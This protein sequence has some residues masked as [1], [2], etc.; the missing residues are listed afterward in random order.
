M[1]AGGRIKMSGSGVWTQNSTFQKQLFGIFESGQAPGGTNGIT[2]NTGLYTLRFDSA[3]LD[4][5][6]SGDDYTVMVTADYGGDDPTAS[7]RTVNVMVQTDSSFQVVWERADT[8]D[9]ENY[10]DD[11]HINFRV[12]LY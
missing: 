10:S 6:T 8:G 9:N 12:W 11:A 3:N 5:I 1:V 7:S 2:R 4:R